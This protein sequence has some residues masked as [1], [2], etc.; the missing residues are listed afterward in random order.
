MR[1]LGFKGDKNCRCVQINYVGLDDPKDLSEWI[2]LVFDQ[3]VTGEQGADWW[4]WPVQWGEFWFLRYC[5][6]TATLWFELQGRAGYDSAAAEL[7]AQ[8]SQFVKD[9]HD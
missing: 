1:L 2:K 6:L 4:I 9:S 5:E 3:Q 8:L 7:C